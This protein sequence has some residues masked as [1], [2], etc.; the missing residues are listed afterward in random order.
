M[1][2]NRTEAF[3]GVEP[4]P[5]HLALDGAAL[6]AYLAPRLPGFGAIESIAKFK[7]GQSNPTYRIT[8]ADRRFVLRRKPPGTLVRS[9]HAIDREYRV[10]AALEPVGIPVA[11]PYLYCADESV[12]GS[13]F[14]VAQCVEGRVFWDADLP[15]I[16]PAGRT[17]IYRAMAD[18][19]GRLHALD[20]AALGLGDLGPSEGYAARNLKRWTDIYCASRL[21]D[22]PDMDALAPALEDRLPTDGQTA[23]IHGDFGLYNMIFAADGPDLRAVLDWEMATL[24][25]PLIDLAHH[26]RA[27]WDIDDGSGAATSLRGLDLPALGI[28]PLEDYAHLYADARGIALPDD[29]GVYIAYAQY[30]YA[31]MIQGILKRAADGTASS[32]RVLHSQDRVFEIAA[33]ARRTLGV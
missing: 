18:T 25:D 19:L 11:K 30:R 28:P 33:L 16:D 4:P 17:A 32:R 15:G 31:A 24:G 23:L 10:M 20:F 21:V 22:I 3:S 8:C 13:H 29:F 1:T 5:P 12:I 26:L 2:S 9:A 6:E 27:W 7:G 14:Y